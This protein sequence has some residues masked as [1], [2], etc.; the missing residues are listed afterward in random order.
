MSASPR[1][2]VKVGLLV[3]AGLLSVIGMIL[4]ADQVQLERRWEITAFLVDAAGLRVDSP[5]TLSGIAVGKVIAV[6]AVPIGELATSPG[7]IR[8]TLEL[9]VGIDLPA[10]VQAKL[11][12]SGLFGDAFLALAAAPSPT[13]QI[14]VK[15]GSARLVVGPGF[16]EKAASRAEGLLTAADDLLAPETRADAKR[17]VKN[18]ADLAEHAASVAARLDAQGARM[19]AILTNLEKAS[20]D[21]T[22]V[23]AA[24]AAR[25]GPLLERADR[26]LT[27]VE[28][29]GGVILSHAAKAS[30][31]LEATAARADALLTATTP[32][33]TDLARDLAA[34]ASST[35]TI[36]TALQTG[37]G[38]LGQLLMNRDLA[39]DV[40][41]IAIDAAAAAKMIAEQ[42]SRVVF[43]APTA[44]R[45]EIKARRER[46]LMRRALAEGFAVPAETKPAP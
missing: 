32:A 40:H 12:S 9:P 16:L 35:R 4:A 44:E 15:D 2:E 46:E 14:M 26:L 23:S 10:D 21:L 3:L 17:L 7:P 24:A 39:G 43:D 45:I 33:L 19:E 20:A 37:Q 34:A 31:S 38:A 5:V 36:L 18:A 25:T 41:R 1:L 6:S 13:G 11:S 27:Q 29:D 30:A 42:P 22:T 8:A 28:Q